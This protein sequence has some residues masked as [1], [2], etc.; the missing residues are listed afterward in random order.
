MSGRA[1]AALAARSKFD[2]AWF[3]ARVVDL[4][5]A[6]LAGGLP[7]TRGRN[8]DPKCEHRFLPFD[9]RGEPAPATESVAK[10]RLNCRCR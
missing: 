1:E 3:F 7:I 6:V 10:G 2:A 4:T 5:L 8:G 9:G